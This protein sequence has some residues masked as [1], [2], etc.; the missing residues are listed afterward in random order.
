M[1]REK[2]IMVIDYVHGYYARL[3]LQGLA[4][5]CELQSD[6]DLHVTALQPDPATTVRMLKPD[7]IIAHIPK[8]FSHIADLA[9]EM[10]IP[11]VCVMER[12]NEN[13]PLVS[14]DDFMTG[15]QAADYFYDAGFRNFGIVGKEGATYCMRRIKGFSDALAEHSLSPLVYQLSPKAYEHIEIGN[16]ESGLFEW[17]ESLEK[18]AAVF[19][20][21]DYF[22][23]QVILACRLNGIAVPEDV[24]ILG[25]DDDDMIWRISRPALSSMRLPFDRVGFQAAE[26]LR[27]MLNGEKVSTDPVLLAPSGI[28]TRHSSDVLATDDPILKRAVQ[29][30]RENIDQPYQV[31]NLLE[32]L[33]VSRTLLEQRFKSVLGRTPLNEIHR[34]KAE[35]ARRLLL[36]SDMTIEAISEKCGFSSG[37]RLT[38][39]FKKFIGV[40]PSEYR[41]QMKKRSGDLY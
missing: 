34:Q 18:P 39:F 29:L 40:T 17:I 6:W 30:I 36:D 8:R 21:N 22:A 11:M 26:L 10:G 13:V 15:R 31:S 1:I 32:K 37:M 41:R 24:A 28:I 19:G 12:A 16:V 14:I 9:Q 27:S 4:H 35:Y 2:Q 25:T 3:M 5:F 38:T 20:C 23:Y 33:V 7:G